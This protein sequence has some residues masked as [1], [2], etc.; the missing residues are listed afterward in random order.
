M[1]ILDMID[2][3]DEVIPP[4]RLAMTKSI[5]ATWA[6][7]THR[8]TPPFVFLLLCMMILMASFLSLRSTGLSL[9]AC[10]SASNE[11]ASTLTS[12]RAYPV[13]FLKFVS[14]SLNGQ[15]VTVSVTSAAPVHAGDDDAGSALHR[16]VQ[17][18][19]VDTVLIGG[20]TWRAQVHKS[21]TGALVLSPVVIQSFPISV[22]TSETSTWVNGWGVAGGSTLVIGFLATHLYI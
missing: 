16:D 14:S 18:K 11:S 4:V 3:F 7:I 10:D 15:T 8:L 5:R 22:L 1:C 19:F 2:I 9:A 12:V 20:T 13:P 17:M 6:I 21:I